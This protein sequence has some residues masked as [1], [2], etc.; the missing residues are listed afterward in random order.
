MQF[1]TTMFIFAFVFSFLLKSSSGCDPPLFLDSDS[2]NC[3]SDCPSQAPL[4]E[5]LTRT[6]ISSCTVSEFFNVSLS[7]CS[8]CPIEC[9]SCVSTNIENEGQ[10][11]QK[12]TCVECRDSFFLSGRCLENCPS[13]TWEKNNNGI[14]GGTCE[15]CSNECD[16]CSGP[17]VFDCLSCSADRFWNDQ[18]KRCESR[19]EESF[20]FY[21][22]DS[23]GREI[24]N[25]FEEDELWN[26]VIQDYLDSQSDGTD[27]CLPCHKSCQT[28]SNPY[29]DSCL[30][31]F[32]TSPL[33]QGRCY[34][35]STCPPG[36]YLNY[37]SIQCVS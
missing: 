28:C 8:S 15:E 14:S 30:S 7:T 20:F 32:G 9:S 21:V 1:E 17:D 12:L 26:S 16:E 13:G 27:L 2:K 10:I 25:Y 18:S 4:P 3:V 29:S 34:P 11:Y 6:C 24:F 23:M 19:C 35:P 31:C 22:E 33:Y 36:L 5:I 37:L